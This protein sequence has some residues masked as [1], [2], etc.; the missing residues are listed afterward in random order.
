MISSFF[1]R[2]L[3][4]SFFTFFFEIGCEDETLESDWKLRGRAPETHPY[5]IFFFCGC[6]CSSIHL[7]SSLS[8]LHMVCF[9]KRSTRQ[10]TPIWSDNLH[11]GYMRSDSL[12]TSCVQPS[13]SLQIL[14]LRLCKQ[15]IWGGIWQ[16]ILERNSADRLEKIDRTDRIEKT[17]KAWLTFE[18]DFP[19]YKGNVFLL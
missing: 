3:I 14:P 10:C 16:L 8:H 18:P 6:P 17:G 5:H 2:I 13:T 1:L 9:P 15:T 7:R 19:G 12:W 11:G 4:L